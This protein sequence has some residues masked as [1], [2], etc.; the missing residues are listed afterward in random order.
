MQ[1]HMHTLMQDYNGLAFKRQVIVGLWLQCKTP[2]VQAVRPRELDGRC[3]VC[4]LQVRPQRIQ[5]PHVPVQH[6]MDATSLPPSQALICF[7]ADQNFMRMNATGSLSHNF[8]VS[9]FSL[10]KF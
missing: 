1:M 3:R 10:Q 7:M 5:L 9:S 4:V 6:N 2:I 8:T